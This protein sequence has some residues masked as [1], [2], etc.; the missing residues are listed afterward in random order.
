M[1]RHVYAGFTLLTAGLLLLGCPEGKKSNGAACAETDV[2]ESICLL[3]MP[4]G[5]CTS[6]CTVFP[7]AEG[8]EC[9]WIAGDNYCMPSCTTDNGCRTGYACVLGVCRP[10]A[11]P[12]I[13]CEE[14]TDCASGLCAGGLCSTDCTIHQDCPEGLY[15]D[16]GSGVCLADDCSSGVC[17]RDCSNHDD[18]A[19]GTYCAET[20]S[21]ELFCAPIPDD[22]GP[23]T[24]GHSC[25]AEACAAGFDCYRRFDGDGDAFCTMECTASTD[26]AP[27]L[28]CRPDNSGTS[29]CLKRDF[30]KA[31]SFDGQ[32]GFDNQRC[33]SA[34]P[35][36]AAGDAYCSTACDPDE[37]ASCPK[38]ADCLEA[39]F[40][41]DTGTWV[42]DC[43]WCSGTCGPVGAAQYQ[44]F[45]YSGACT[46]DGGLCSPCSHSGECAADGHCLAIFDS[47]NT[48]CTAPCNGNVC[49]AGYF[50]AS[51]DGITAPQCV[52]RSGSCEEPSSDK[53]QCDYCSYYVDGDFNPFADCQTGL[54][55]EVTTNNNYCYNMCST[56][57]DPCPAYTECNLVSEY[58]SNWNLCRP[59]G[60]LSCNQFRQCIQHC[61]TGPTSCDGT[62]P[63]NCVNFCPNGCGTNE[64]CQVDQCV[65]AFA[66]CTGACCAA[67]QVCD[68]GGACCSPDCVGKDCGDD[69][70]GGSCG[71]C[72]SPATCDATGMCN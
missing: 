54:C 53:D 5:I 59:T 47:T 60:S 32:C 20:A 4:D 19:S 39:S 21:G 25:A 30:C 68:G 31:C 52:P 34:D 41:E 57:M 50:C 70:C 66:E 1:K 16:G 49:A 46:G 58:G 71:I 6:V 67:N 38:D 72:I 27:G 69:G 3:G 26:C 36:V 43:A 18:C 28:V 13:P 63:A 23:G 8:E 35:A 61:P 45:H 7:C 55:V 24:L 40:C 64:E 44:C 9:L 42:A 17:L 22:G 51:I 10:P 14:D 12:G 33:V 15:C 65:C 62:A 29:Y 2:C 11:G 48:T 37:S 56:G